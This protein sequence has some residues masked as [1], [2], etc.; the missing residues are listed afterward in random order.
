[1]K[2]N[3]RIWKL[4]L[5]KHFFQGAICRSSPSSNVSYTRYGK[6]KAEYIKKQ[7]ENHLARR[8]RG[9]T[10]PNVMPANNTVLWKVLY[11][12]IYSYIS[13]EI[14][15]IF[16]THT[17]ASYSLRRRWG[18]SFPQ[19]KQK[20]KKECNY[21]KPPCFYG[22]QVDY[23]K[24]LIDKRFCNTSTKLSSTYLGNDAQSNNTQ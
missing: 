7:T 3:I 12:F 18:S 4:K 20:K 5:S 8:L 15:R 11:I 1:M 13:R 22:L 19:Q 2:R 16:Q 21:S 14:R 24:E 10:F 23:K 6:E 17:S 9:K